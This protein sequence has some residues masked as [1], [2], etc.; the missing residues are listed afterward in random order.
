M[1]QISNL[2]HGFDLALPTLW[3]YNISEKECGLGYVTARIF[4][5]PSSKSPKL[6]KLESSRF[7]HSFILAFTTN[8]NQNISVWGRGVIHVTPRIFSIPQIYLQNR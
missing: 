2:V 3:E 6:V 4:G 1:L 8:L 7:V 5:I